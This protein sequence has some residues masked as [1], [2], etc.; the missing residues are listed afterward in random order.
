M[1]CVQ[2]IVLAS[3][4]E[5]V[6][7]KVRFRFHCIFENR[8]VLHHSV[9]NLPRPKLL[10]IRAKTLHLADKALEIQRKHVQ[11]VFSVLFVF[12]QLFILH[13]RVK[14]PPRL[15]AIRTKMLLV[16]NKVLQIQRKQARCV[17]FRFSCT[18]SRYLSPIRHNK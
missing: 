11:C 18:T 6:V 8:Y 2:H 5:T 15:L 7:T 17:L 3:G 1:R 16:A 9:K 12:E 14:Q 4:C 10:A 13:H